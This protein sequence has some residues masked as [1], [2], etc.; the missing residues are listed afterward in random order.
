[1]RSSSINIV[2]QHIE[3]VI[4]A[5]AIGFTG[6]LGYIYFL[7]EPY[8][9]EYNGQQAGP[10]NLDELILKKAQDLDRRIKDTTVP[11]IE[12][13]PDYSQ[14]LERQFEEGL[15]PRTF[16][17]L[18]RSV[19][20]GEPLMIK[21]ES[22]DPANPIPLVRPLAPSASVVTRG[23]SIVRRRQVSFAEGADS[24]A[25]TA[26]VSWISVSALWDRGAQAD[27][28]KQAGY[29]SYRQLPYMLPPDVQ[30]QELLD[31]GE[32]SEWELVQNSDAMPAFDVPELKFN[33]NT[34]QLENKLAIDDAFQR[35]K[36]LQLNLIQPRFFDVIEGDLWLIP[37]LKGYSDSD[38]EARKEAMAEQKDEGRGRGGRGGGR[39]GDDDDDDGEGGRG[40]G[41]G[42]DGG[43][44]GGD[45]RDGGGDGGGGGRRGDFVNA[46]DGYRQALQAYVEGEY[47]T[48]FDTIEA[49]IENGEL[50]GSL[51]RDAENLKKLIEN[52]LIRYEMARPR[53][54]AGGVR[55]VND[56]DQED[57]YAMWFNDDTVVPGKTY[58]YRL[59]ANLW[60]RYVNQPIGLANPQDSRLVA[61]PGEWSEPTAAVE[62]V[63]AHEVYVIRT[64]AD[65]SIKASVWTWHRGWW[66]EETF[67]VAIGEEIGELTTV[68]SPLAAMSEDEDED[69]GGGRR[70]PRR[71]RAVEEVDFR[72]G[73]VLV[74]VRQ[75]EPRG[76]RDTDA[77]GGV[78]YS[79]SNTSL[80]VVTDKNTGATY[81]LRLF[82]GRAPDP[83]RAKSKR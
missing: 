12:P 14:Q 37:P 78:S 30:R 74:D 49:V 55:Q 64:D 83:N 25:V 8:T 43:G 65:R 15:W 29:V 26:P 48:A 28:H 80:A 47:K 1:M 9:V 31:S 81:E 42:G 11:E 71:D 53:W 5:A 4:L 22:L 59:R 18:D 67:Q 16:G 34:G 23:R 82:K 63:P 72:T 27:A 17:P 6:Y 79:T 3:K 10:T 36:S 61:L 52:R 19:A 56:P 44:G 68:R 54:M 66:F 41:R 50:R 40:G 57:R 35:V 2:E 60:N 13:V 38:L 77:R 32:W 24:D 39:G 51:S 33:P 76:E 62:A 58:R 7:G 73:L 70:R 20:F 45:G 21:G 75:D 46:E 69:D